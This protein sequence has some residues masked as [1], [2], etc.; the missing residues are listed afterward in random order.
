MSEL[1]RDTFPPIEEPVGYDLGRADQI[2]VDQVIIAGLRKD[3]DIA[4]PAFQQSPAY[5]TA[6]DQ[7]WNNACDAIEAAIGASAETEPPPAPE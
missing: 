2:A 4:P 7:G 3:I 6:G 5:F 1:A